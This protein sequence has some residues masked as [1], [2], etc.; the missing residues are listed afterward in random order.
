MPSAI[1][2]VLAGGQQLTREAIAV[3]E[4][5][6]DDVAQC[7]DDRAGQRG[8]VHDRGRLE[9]LGIGQRI[10]QDQAAFGVGVENLDRL[11]RHAAD[12]VAGLGCA[13]P[14]HVLA[15]GD[16]SDHIDGRFQLSKASENAH[17]AA[18][19]AHVVLHFVHCIGRLERDAAGIECDALADE[20]DRLLLPRR[21]VV[22]HDDE[23]R[24]L[25]AGSGYR[26][27]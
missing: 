4:K 19:A 24:C 27:E 3:A 12:D 8:D 9:A 21:A 5:S 20:H 1:V 18:C 11:S 10:A 26:Q 22:L 14:G 25:R 6:G 23:A 2:G 15:R 13:R 17:D 16:Q 7:N